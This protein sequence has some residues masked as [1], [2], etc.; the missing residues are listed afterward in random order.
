MTI[1]FRHLL[2]SLSVILGVAGVALAD[3]VMNHE[4]GTYKLTEFGDTGE[5]IPL[6]GPVIHVFS[7]DGK[8]YTTI[9]NDNEN[10]KHSSRVGGVCGRR[11]QDFGDA[12]IKV[13][14]VTH[15][16]R[17]TGGHVIENHTETFEFPFTLPDI[18]RTPPAACNFELD[19]RVAQAGKSREYWMKRGFVVRYENAYEA[20]FGASCSGGLAR[21]EFDTETI[22]TPVWIACAPADVDEDPAPDLPKRM[23]AS[24]ARKMPLKVRA[25]LEATQQGTIYTPECPVTVRYTG[26]IWVSRPNTRVTYRIV[27][28]DWD[29]PERTITI[30]KA[31]N[32][33][34]TGWTQYYR[35][36]ETDVGRV[37]AAPEDAR[38]QPDAAG[39][40]RLEVEF[41]GGSAQSDAIPYEVF[42]NT[43]PPKRAILKKI[44]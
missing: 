39:S 27:G 1:R 12:W 15:D 44:D 19:K 26:S 5:H 6:N 41:E 10:L 22:K 40:V 29:S 30:Q 2:L 21:G 8:S 18:P 32:Q 43:E 23:P 4:P 37:S 42:C 3:T 14:G 11:S 34:I 7:K 35:E 36:R 38:P 28:T 16:V 33:E 13:A 9:A 31:G 24:R 20:K 17:G 25:K